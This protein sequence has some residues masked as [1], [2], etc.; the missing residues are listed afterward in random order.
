MSDE[1]GI[2][3]LPSIPRDV[4]QDLC[5]RFLINIPENEKNNLVRICFQI[6]LAHWYYID[7]SRQENPDLPSCDMKNFI[8]IIF[9]EFEFLNKKKQSVQSIY[10][11]WKQYK[12]RVPVY[13]AIL[14]DEELENCLLVKGF[15]KKISWGFPKGKVN[16]DEGGLECA[17]REVWEETGYDIR[18]IAHPDQFIEN[19]IH[20]HQVRLYIVAGVVKNFDFKPNTR[21]EI[22]E[23]RWF[24]I[25]HL[26]TH[27]KDPAP[28]EVFGLFA[29]NFF[30]IHTFIKPLRKWIQEKSESMG[31]FK[32]K[33]PITLSHPECA[34]VLDDLHSIQQKRHEEA[35]KFRHM[36]MLI[37]PLQSSKESENTLKS[38]LGLNTSKTKIQTQPD[39]IRKLLTGNLDISPH[40]PFQETFKQS[41]T[42][43]N[44]IVVQH[45][46][47]QYINAQSHSQSFKN[48]QVFENQVV[49]SKLQHEIVSNFTKNSNG[50]SQTKKSVNVD[51]DVNK[52]GCDGEKQISVTLSVTSSLHFHNNRSLE[53]YDNEVPFKGKSDT[54]C[55]IKPRTSKLSDFAF[56]APAFLNF[57]FNYDEI[58]SKLNC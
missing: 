12:V 23:I 45:E 24:P 56:K 42:C 20:D 37:N 57:K 8:F 7:F 58:L 50:Q 13:G 44:D 27:K 15:H 28:K 36:H 33:P 53:C 19:T 52:L 29:N 48:H 41:V 40:H 4:L 34:L 11:N 35:E 17:A 49:K 9:N 51:Q 22:K 43:S 10:E 14:L 25:Q 3:H 32:I 5:S 1:N 16:K 39:A 2:Q 55:S 21:G 6:E 30:M 18:P 47:K 46:N 31:S 38:L 54:K 26:P